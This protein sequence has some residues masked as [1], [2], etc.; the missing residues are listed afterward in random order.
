MKNKIL[1][2]Y[3]ILIV[4]CLICGCKPGCNNKGAV[5]GP[6]PDEP[7]FNWD[8]TGNIYKA[9]VNIQANGDWVDELMIDKKQAKTAVMNASN[10]N[11]TV[12][13]TGLNGALYSW[14]RATG[15]KPWV[16]P[17][18]TLP[19]GKQAPLVLEAGKFGLFKVPF[20]YIYLAVGQRAKDVETLAKTKK[21]TANL[22]YEILSKAKKDDMDCVVLCAISTSVFA[23]AGKESETNKDFTLDE[24][25]ANLYEGMKQGI[26][27]FQHEN[28]NH[29][30]KII[31]NNWN[32]TPIGAEVVKLVKILR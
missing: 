25:L 21:L 1:N 18:P 17:H 7:S 28:P 20:G 8:L 30:L 2:R 19:D 9:A 10:E 11:I 23:E 24:F 27:K 26:G 31:L 6:N 13:G 3:S 32:R 16:A 15:L 14:A 12:G 5:G 29:K 4:I 22:Y